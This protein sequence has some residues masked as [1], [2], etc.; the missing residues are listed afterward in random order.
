[1]QDNHTHTQNNLWDYDRG[2]GEK[3]FRNDFPDIA[4]PKVKKRI[5]SH[6]KGDYI[7]EK[8][9]GC[10]GIGFEIEKSKFPE[11]P[12]CKETIYNRYGAV[13]ER[14]GSVSAGFELKTPIY[15]LFSSQTNNRLYKLKKFVDIVGK[16][17]AG[18]HINLSVL[19]MPPHKLLDNC[20]GFLPF[21]YAM[22]KKRIH[23]TYCR[24]KKV[25]QLKKDRDKFQSIRIHTEHI[26]FR[27]IGPVYNYESLIFRLNFFRIMCKNLGK[28]FFNILNMAITEGSELYNLL[29]TDVYSDN[30][31]FL[32]LIQDSIQLDKDFGTGKISDSVRNGILDKLINK[33]KP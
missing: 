11:F 33:L 25:P 27:I 20:R 28:S 5:F 29:R 15:N 23:N 16:D 21:I 10:F 17:N 9:S 30:D 13:L 31:K 18:G 22:H 19:G 1:M 26:E 4:S 8:R 12:F 3:D 32:R 7:L 14:D 6:E 2:P 24:A